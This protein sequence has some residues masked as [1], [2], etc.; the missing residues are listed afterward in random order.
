MMKLH[1]FKDAFWHA[2]SMQLLVSFLLSTLLTPLAYEF[3]P[4]QL[5]TPLF[6]P[7]YLLTVRLFPTG[8]HAGTPLTVAIILV[9]IVL[10]AIVFY[11]GLRFVL[12]RWTPQ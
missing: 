8:V 11:F 3:L 12:R 6:F 7:G 4:D 5:A 2:R 1:A 10:Y 9:S